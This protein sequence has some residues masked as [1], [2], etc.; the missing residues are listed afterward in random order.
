MNKSLLQIQ[1]TP[2]AFIYAGICLGLM[3]IFY[4]AFTGQLGMMIL[5]GVLPLLFLSVAYALKSPLY[6][7]LIFFIGNY[8]IMT[9]NRYAN[10]TGVSLVIDIL[11]VSTILVTLIQSALFENIPW[12]R[13]KNP[14]TLGTFIW[15][16]YTGLEVINPNSK[17]EAWV[18][19]RQLIYGCLAVVILTCVLF[20]KKKYIFYFIGIL[21]VFSFIAALKALQQK[22]I[23]WDAG[24]TKFLFEDGGAIT[25]LIW[26]GTRY[27]SIFTDASNFG[28]NMGFATLIY[29]VIGFQ[30]KNRGLRIWYLLVA[31]L[32]CYCMFISGTRGAIIVPLGGLAY[33]SLLSKNIKALAISFSILTV[34]FCFFA[35]TTIG[36][37]NGYIWRMRTAFNA[38]ED[39]SYN[40]RVENQKLIGAYMKDKY[41]G[42][43]LGLGGVEA[44]RFG[45]TYINSIPVDSWYVK[46]WVE[47]GI[48]G[49]TLYLI[50][51]TSSLIWGSYLLMNKLK[52][53]Q[54]RG[55]MAALASGCFGMILSAYGNSFFGQYPTHFLVFISLALLSISP[56]LDKEDE[57]YKSYY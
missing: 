13:I 22:F 40:V 25:H 43:G 37:S 18:A 23:G 10:L 32:S 30:V 46:L 34:L 9:F 11:I 47:T 27:F 5:V 26:S 35:F 57:K 44:Q 7:F 14:V 28:S 19:S 16:I 4:T 38:S 48:I 1:A 33:F 20:T 24:E 54:L 2:K 21:S 31:T 41:F 56:Y 53:P 55:A 51:Y 50:I 6:C 12:G 52:D 45:K 29:G 8:F 17:I 3:S 49:V 15:M 36:N 42:E 39:A